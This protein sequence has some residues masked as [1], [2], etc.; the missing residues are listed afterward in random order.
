M[1]EPMPV[2]I[3]RFLTQGMSAEAVAEKTSMPLE[4]VQQVAAG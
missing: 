2:V 1:G 4:I 3:Q